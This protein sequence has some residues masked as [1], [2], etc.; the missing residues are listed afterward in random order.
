MSSME[1]L[2]TLGKMVRIDEYEIGTLR[3]RLTPTPSS[4]PLPSPP[5]PS[6]FLLWDLSSS[7]SPLLDT[8]SNSTSL[9]SGCQYEIDW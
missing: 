2:A 3:S 9:V 8:P 4:P 6:S 5:F 7:W 1:K